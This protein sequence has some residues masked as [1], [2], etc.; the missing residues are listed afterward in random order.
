M[1]LIAF[2]FF[3]LGALAEILWLWRQAQPDSATYPITRHT[4]V[5]GGLAGLALGLGLV[6]EVLGWEVIQVSLS[7]TWVAFIFTLLCGFLFLASLA[8]QFLPRVNEQTILTV[9]VLITIHLWLS[10]GNAHWAAL[11]FIGLLPASISLYLVL[12]Q[13]PV[14]PLG[15]ALIYFWYLLSLLVQAAQGGGLDYFRLN[16]LAPIEG[17][18]FGML[19]V[20]LIL[21][22]LFALRFFL[23]VSSLLRPRNRRLVAQAMPVLFYDDQLPVRPFLILLGALGA[24]LICLRALHL[25]GYPLW[26][27][28]S[29][30]LVV[31]LL[32]NPSLT[33]QLRHR[34]HFGRSD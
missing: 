17:L 22:G 5:V 34:F 25:P 4:L 11:L 8:P 6:L 13:T 24:A 20:F 27:N 21:H 32:F 28:L 29:L 26:L 7:N 16:R 1:T 9:Q 31:Q 19:F 18:A 23:I 15:K 14:P 3:M 30:L 33:N 12:R 10:G 2:F